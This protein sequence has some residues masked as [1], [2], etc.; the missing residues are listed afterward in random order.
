MSNPAVAGNT[1]VAVRWLT[2]AIELSPALLPVYPFA[3]LLLLSD[4]EHR[5]LTD[6]E[7]TQ[8]RP[9]AEKLGVQFPADAPAPVPAPEPAPSPPAPPPVQDPDTSLRNAAAYFL[10]T[11]DASAL[12]QVVRDQFLPDPSEAGAQNTVVPALPVTNLT[13]LTP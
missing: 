3:V 9:L 13:E 5:D 8:L 1:H 7:L 2:Q 4:E 10:S 12:L 11:S 6:E